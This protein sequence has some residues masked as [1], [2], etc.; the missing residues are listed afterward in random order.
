MSNL[1][2]SLKIKTTMANNKVRR[3]AL[4]VKV[5]ELKIDESHISKRKLRLLN[6]NFI[7]AKWLYNY[8]VSNDNIFDFNSKVKE[9]EVKKFNPETQKCDISTIRPLTIG[10]QIKQSIVDR[11][12]QNVYNLAKAKRAGLEIGQLKVKKEVNSIPLKQFGV[13]FKIKNDKYI[14]IQGVG[15]LRVNGLWQIKGVDIANAVLLKKASGYFVK[16]TIYKE[17][18]NT[19][20]NGQFIGIDFGIKD[21][22]VLSNGEKYNY[23]FEIP[24]G[25][26]SKQRRLSKKKKNSKNYIKQCQKIKKSYEKYTNRKN[27]AANKVVANLKKY[28]TVV[29][30]DENIKGWHMNLFGKQVQQSILGRIKTRLKELETSIMIDRWLPTTKLSPVSGKIINISLNERTFSDGVY[31][32]DRDIKSAKTI[33]A[34]GLYDPKLTRKELMSLPA[35][36]ITS[37]FPDY[38]FGQ[39]KSLSMKQEATAL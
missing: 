21:S 3:A 13:T 1:E 39:N 25:L 8:I 17:K 24:K 5:F 14:S 4:S 16:V 36:A 34:F 26:K 7:Q 2:K 12:I 38:M 27:D 15:L 32:E 10:S 19:K 9:I 35:E 22:I 20:T 30:Q 18:N 6:D 11:A 29:F 33:L 28:D 37:I 31:Q 23:Q